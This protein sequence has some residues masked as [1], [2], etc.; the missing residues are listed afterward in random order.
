M[1]KSAKIILAVVCSVVLIVPAIVLPIV[2]TGPRTYSFTKIEVRTP[3]D[4][5]TLEVGE[6]FSILDLFDEVVNPLIPE[7]INLLDQN[8]LEIFEVLDEILYQME[9]VNNDLEEIFDAVRMILDLLHADI[10]LWDPAGFAVIDHHFDL[11]NDFMKYGVLISDEWDLVALVGALDEVAAEFAQWILDL[12][13]LDLG[14]DVQDFVTHFNLTDPDELYFWQ[15]AAY[16][17]YADFGLVMTEEI[18]MVFVEHA[19]K[20]LSEDANGFKT[21]AIALAFNDLLKDATGFDLL[22]LDDM[23]NDMLEIVSDLSITLRRGNFIFNDVNDIVEAILD[24]FNIEGA[25][26]IMGAVE[27]IIED[28]L[29]NVIFERG[30]GGVRNLY[31]QY[32]DE[33]IPF[34][35]AV[36]DMLGIV[37]MAEL[38]D[39]AE[40]TVVEN[41]R[42]GTL[43]LDLDFDIQGI[44]VAA[45]DPGDGEPNAMLDLVNTI[46]GNMEFG[47]SIVFSR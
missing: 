41:R 14:I 25:D 9:N 32:E 27:E 43:T 34:F 42:A 23:V 1:S 2:L 16:L 28:L 38:Y 21:S 45:I 11:L 40:F 12:P 10:V 26:E 6:E 47:I 31:I 5:I 4:N 24:N 29:S 33:Q 19:N 8:W 22:T 15:V 30:D 44:L 17:M 3:F 35:E 39:F 7:L 13:M 18:F 20:I 46:L 37:G 36:V